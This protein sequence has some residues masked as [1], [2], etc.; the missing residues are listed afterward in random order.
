MGAAS[1]KQAIGIKCQFVT[2]VIIYIFA[3]IILHKQ[4]PVSLWNLMYLRY[5]R[6]DVY[7]IT[8]LTGLVNK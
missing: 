4:M 7:A 5:V 3:F 6:Y 8:D 2:E 1:K